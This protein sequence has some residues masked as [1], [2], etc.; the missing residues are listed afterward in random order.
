MYTYHCFRYDLPLLKKH[1]YRHTIDVAEQ[2]NKQHPE[3]NTKE[4]LDCIRKSNYNRI[5]GKHRTDLK[6]PDEDVLKEDPIDNNDCTDMD[7]IVI[8]EHDDV[9]VDH[10][11]KDNNGGGFLGDGV[12]VCKK[13]FDN[14]LNI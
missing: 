12:D 13:E 6:Q 11:T 5:Y 10:K 3:Q 2:M 7:D 1:L 8:P 4:I 9:F 14:D